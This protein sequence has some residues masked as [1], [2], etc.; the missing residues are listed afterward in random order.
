VIA[1][2][3]FTIFLSAFLVF[4]IQPLMG[5]V[6][7]PYLGSAP[8]IWSVAMFSYQAF[9][10]LGYLYGH[11]LNKKFNIT[12]QIKIHLAVLFVSAL[13]LPLS[14]FAS[15]LESAIHNPEIWLI[16][17]LSQNIALFFILLS[18]NT[19]II[20]NLIANSKYRI[21]ENP[22]ILY[23]ASNI[24]SLGAL[25]LYHFA[26][27]P[28]FTI[29]G[30]MKIW[31]YLYGLFIISFAVTSYDFFKSR[32]TNLVEK[33]IASIKKISSQQKFKWVLLAF[34]PSAL[35]L[36]VTQFITND[37]SPLPFLW[38][39]TLAIYLLTFILAFKNP[40]KFYEIASPAQI[41]A[42]FLI[43]L[44]LLLGFDTTYT[45]YFIA[46]YLLCF[47]I[48]SLFCHSQL[49]RTAPHKAYLSEFYI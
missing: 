3:A 46:I 39:I 21:S 44:L 16:K 17:S 23:A 48:I 24:G 14:F 43:M 7:L 22:Y 26:I 49:A 6:L 5:K 20:Q 28:N 11:F 10:L 38:I 19:L 1:I 36:S 4:L 33:N 31:S 2:Y 37:L 29:L 9:L 40:N 12:K 41:K 25:L 18:A 27:E 32:I 47:F 15:N 42:S 8:Q 35:M 13:F 45:L 30:T 34:L